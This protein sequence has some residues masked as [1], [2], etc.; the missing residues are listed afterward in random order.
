VAFT[1]T[2]ATQ[3][4]PMDGEN[5][6]ARGFPLSAYCRF[7]WPMSTSPNRFLLTKGITWLAT[8]SILDCLA[9]GKVQ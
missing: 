8:L 4:N 1:Y 6:D 7:L 3:R 5:D 9:G 2:K